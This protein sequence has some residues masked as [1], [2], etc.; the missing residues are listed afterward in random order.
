MQ[1]TIHIRKGFVLAL[2]PAVLAAILGVAYLSWPTANAV[3]TTPSTNLDSYALFAL[4]EI[5]VK[6]AAVHNGNVGVNNAGG[7]AN[8]ELGPKHPPGYYGT[9][10]SRRALNLSAVIAAPRL[11]AD[12]PSGVARAVYTGAREFDFRPWLLSLALALALIDLFVSLALRGV[13][14]RQARRTTAAL[15]LAAGALLNGPA[16]AQPAQRA[17]DQADDTGAVLA[18]MTTRSPADVS[19]A[20]RQDMCR[21]RWSSSAKVRRR[22]SEMSASVSGEVEAARSR[23]SCNSIAVSLPEE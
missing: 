4:E 9:E 3:P 19:V 5:Q 21:T 7:F 12:L 22:P 16:S 11:I 17:P 1:F 15:L 14:D 23:I 18:T 8:V 2:V 6:G 13:W 20:R 10:T